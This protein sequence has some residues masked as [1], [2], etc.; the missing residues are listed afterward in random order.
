MNAKYFAG[1]SYFEWFRPP[2]AS[3]AI[4]LLGFVGWLAAEY[5]YIL[6]VSA[7]HLISS[8]EFADIY[9]IDKKL[10]YAFSL[11]P[12]LFM[13]AFSVGTELLSLSLIQ[14]FLAYLNHRKAGI[15]LG[16]AM[17]ARYPNMI[18]LP[19]LLFQRDTKTI[20]VSVILFAITLSPWLLF[21]YYYTG[22]ALTSMADS[23][24]INFLFRRGVYENSFNPVDILFAINITLPLF[25]LGM[26]KRI[27]NIKEK[28]LV[29]LLLFALTLFSFVNFP[30]KYPRFLFHLIIPAAYFAACADIGKRNVAAPLFAAASVLILMLSPTA[31]LENTAIYQR[32]SADNDC[33]TQSNVWVPLNYYGR[34]AEPFPYMEAVNESVQSGYRIVLLK[35]VSDPS[36]VS[37]T[38]FLHSFPAI[39]ETETYIILGDSDKCKPSEKYDQTFLQR[40]NEYYAKYKYPLNLTPLKALLSYSIPK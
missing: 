33:A 23:Y 1:G 24:A 38:T 8:M 34:A 12:F 31:L 35:Y 13:Y 6:A 27:R 40:Q 3:F 36:Y 22:D 14:L 16:L 32:L 2:L 30:L 4:F 21:N 11:T 28:E 5:L 37:N 19:L 10:Y 29:L 15:F 25:L 9:N 18:Y 7:L 20:M 39:E 17:L 26:A